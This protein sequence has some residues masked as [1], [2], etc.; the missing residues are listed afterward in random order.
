MRALA[1][2]LAG[3]RPDHHHVG[4]P[5]AAAQPAGAAGRLATLLVAATAP[6]PPRRRPAN[7]AHS[8]QDWRL[9]ARRR[10]SQVSA[11]ASVAAA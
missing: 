2:R 8:A 10:R 4:T 6:P 3:G 9:P 1:D 5:L 7:P 11:A